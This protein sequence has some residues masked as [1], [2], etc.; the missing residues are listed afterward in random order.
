[1]KFWLLIMTDKLV[2]E[3][4]RIIFNWLIGVVNSYVLLVAVANC[5]SHFGILC[6]P[7]RVLRLQRMIKESKL[8]PGYLHMGIGG[9]NPFHPSVKKGLRCTC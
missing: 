3:L 1:M 2:R 5:R 6:L 7:T 9:E 4:R 8:L